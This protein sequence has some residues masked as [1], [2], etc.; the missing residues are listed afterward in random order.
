MMRKWMVAAVAAAVLLLLVPGAILA[1]TLLPSIYGDVQYGG[2]QTGKIVVCALPEGGDSPI[3][4]GCVVIDGPGPFKLEELPLGKYDVCAF[5]DL[6]GDENGPP[7]PEEPFGCSTT[8]V[9]LSGGNSV[10]G[11]AV[12]LQDP[13]PE[14]VPEPGSMILLGSGLAGLAGYASLRWRNRK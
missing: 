3:T 5:L 8:P 11:V 1:V 4:D 10:R 13:E 7:L 6:E 2:S 12:V 9:D 14:F